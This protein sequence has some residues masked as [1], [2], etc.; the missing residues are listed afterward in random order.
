MAMALL[1]ILNSCKSIG[2]GGMKG[3]GQGR[4]HL[5]S[6]KTISADFCSS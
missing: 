1:T 4:C 6:G 3:G 5:A 2:V